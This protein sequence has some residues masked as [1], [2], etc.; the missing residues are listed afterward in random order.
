MA[1]FVHLHNHTHFSLL[2][3]A[4]RI[5]DLISQAKAYKM[6]ALAITDHGNMFGAIQFYQKCTAE[7]LK[8]I[9]G[10]ETYVAPHSRHEKT[11]RSDGEDK[12]HHLILLAK[13]ET[14]YKNLM[15]LSSIGYL[16]GFYY[17]PRIDKEVLDK[18]GDGLVVLSSCIQGEVPRKI[19]DENPDGA[20]EA[21]CWFKDR[22]GDDYYLEIQNHGIPEESKAI[23][24]LFDLSKELDVPLVATNDTHY[25]KREH[26]EAQDILLCIQTGKDWDDPKRMKFTTDEIYFKSP[27]EMSELF[28]DLPESLTNTLEVAE[29]CNVT[30]DF[31]TQYFPHFQVPENE[32][33]VSLT[34]NEYF[35]KLAWEGATKRYAEI[36]PEVEERLNFEINVIEQ[37]GYPSYFLITADFINHAKDHGIPVGPGRG[38]AAGSM[39]SYVMGITDVEPLE[40]NLLFERFLNPERVSMPDIDIDFCYERRE[41]VIDYV[42]R[43]YGGETNVTQIITFGSMNARAVVRDVGRVLN[44]PYGDVDQIAKL[45]PPNAK[46]KEAIDKVAEFRELVESNEINQKL[47]TNSLV[48]EGLARHASTHAAGVVIAPGELTQY[49]PLYKPPNGEVTT[50]FDMK[51]LEKAGLLKMDFLGL[52]TL[53]VVDHTL[54]ALSKRGIEID[55]DRIPLD[56]AKTYEIFA[57]GQTVGVFQFESSGMREYLCKLNP[58]SISD[59]TAMNALYRPGPMDW[60]DDF[61]D[62]KHGRKEIE[63]MHPMLESILNETYGIIVYQEQVMQIAAKL[64]GFS[65]GGAD[66]LRRAMGKKDEELMKKQRQEFI[67]GAAKNELSETC[68]NAIFDLIFKF[69]GYGFNKSHATCYSIVAYQ[70]AYLKAHYPAEFMAA[71]LSSEMQNTDRIVILIED[72]RRIGI[73]VLPPDVN[74]SLFDFVALPEGIRYGLGAVK[75]VGKNAIQSIVEAREKHGQFK[76]LFDFCKNLNL[77]QVNKKVFESLIQVGAMDT[78]EGN[79]AQQM[80]LLEKAIGFAQAAQQ[81]ASLGQFSIFG[82]DGESEEN[83]YPDLP[84]LADW[85]EADRLQREKDLLGLYISGHPLDKFREEVLT[86]SNPPIELLSETDSGSKVRICGIVS[87]LQT[88]L[89]RRNNQM[90]FF[91]LEDFTGNVRCIAFSSTY[92]EIRETLQPE[93]LVVVTGKL[94]RR[95]DRDESTIMVDQAVPLEKASVELVKQITLEIHPQKLANGEIDRLKFL[96]D[97]YPGKCPVRFEVVTNPNEKF[98]LTSK[99]CKVRPS[100]ALIEGVKELIGS[101][102]LHLRG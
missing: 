91:T 74:S 19:I 14:G 2:D 6:N 30:L 39:V 85:P 101:E 73:N 43:K 16:E 5:A 29:K 78:L 65:L 31:K 25:L 67:D 3:G 21:A 100:P 54:K 63:Y 18:Y 48:L 20:R 12:S 59:L 83:T 58:E 80:T 10:F 60:I 70:T 93:R 95:D 9:L 66:I 97:K 13:D 41:E 26:A 55:I 36:T 23:R 98:V 77:R 46:L 88:K 69:A 40:Y 11:K 75:N 64:G 87:Q 51:S 47:L 37:M 68:A 33:P 34:L 42:R 56:D 15:K 8:P 52:R 62:R 89:D 32:E 90:A 38:S 72:C 44:I 24:G 28:K 45:I 92:N 82:G 84:D 96:F 49:V 4:C 61:I 27:E 102:C 94:D 17:K 35:R 22:F 71:N 53:T 7:G 79:R 99:S 57:N 86:F 76:T 50:Q 1:E 81:E